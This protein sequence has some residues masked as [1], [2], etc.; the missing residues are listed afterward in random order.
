M[1]EDEVVAA[2]I[3]GS[4]VDA[5]AAGVQQALDLAAST[6]TEPTS[7]LKRTS[8][9]RPADGDGRDEAGDER[10][11]APRRTAVGQVSD[12]VGEHRRR[13]QHDDVHLF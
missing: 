3:N 10:P 8:S 7:A 11:I 2:A 13:G 1:L 12:L 9:P 6:A 5:R 4:E